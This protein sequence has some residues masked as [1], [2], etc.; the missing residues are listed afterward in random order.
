VATALQLLFQYVDGKRDVEIAANRIWRSYEQAI[1]A[2]VYTFDEWQIKLLLNGISGTSVTHVQI[3]DDNGNIIFEAGKTAKQDE[4]TQSFPI[5]IDTKN[6]LTGQRNTLEWDNLLNVYSNAYA[7]IAKDGLSNSTRDRKTSSINSLQSLGTIQLQSSLLPLYATLWKSVYAMLILNALRAGVVAVA[8]FLLLKRYLSTPVHS[9]S[10][11]AERISNGDYEKKVAVSCPKIPSLFENEV[12]LLAKSMESMR[13]QM[14]ISLLNANQQI[15]KQQELISPTFETMSDPLLLLS[16]EGNF[17]YV[18]PAAARQLFAL[19]NSSMSQWAQANLL[20]IVFNGTIL[21]TA[22][23]TH[24]NK[25]LRAC[26]AL[27]PAT[28]NDVELELK[29]TK[30]DETLTFLLTATH[31]ESSGGALLVFHNITERK[32]LERELQNAKACAE[33]ADRAKSDFLAF[34]SHEVRSPLAAISMAL[35][36]IKKRDDLP[37]AHGLL[38]SIST[39]SN[40]IINMLNSTLN[41][42]RIDAGFVDVEISNFSPEKMIREIS[43]LFTPQAFTQHTKIELHLSRNLPIHVIGDQNHIHQILN[44]LFSNAAKF[45]QNGTI[46]ISADWRGELN[47]FSDNIVDKSEENG[48]LRICVSDTGCG[49][50]ADSIAGI[51]EP[52][53][54]AGKYQQRARG[55][56]LGL[57]I[58]KSLAE[59][60]SG[61][62]TVKSQEGRGSE[63]TL[64][65]PLLTGS[66][67][68]PE[69]ITANIPQNPNIQ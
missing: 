61:S 42:A 36:L 45:T 43:E 56:G 44:N 21:E 19:Q 7:N 48:V 27:D 9:L 60:M 41:M 67:A 29:S 5:T 12:S 58:A 33:A 65:I 8:F 14:N 69:N 40:K 32:L 59:R 63:F 30:Q 62:I 49:I 17:E 38:Q 54:Q 16:A 46:K 2:S 11:E 39:S 10:K 28:S 13:E 1:A 4:V 23:L 68:L 53:R 57:A 18:N 47:N 55:T 66:A 15:S 37:S 50:P 31:I 26:F 6:A 22:K 24:N 52:Y 51:F 20:K 25:L 34:M 3:V 64:T 35:E